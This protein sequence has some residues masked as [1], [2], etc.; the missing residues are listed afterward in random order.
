[1]E[2]L[3]QQI[4]EMNPDV[5]LDKDI[6][7][8]LVGYM[9]RASDDYLPVYNKDFLVNA[10]KMPEDSEFNSY[11]TLNISLSQ[12]SECEPGCL[13][14]DGFDDAII[15]LVELSDGEKVVLY[16]TYKCIDV[17]KVNGEMAEEDAWDYFYHKTVGTYM[18]EKTPAFMTSKESLISEDS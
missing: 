13:I 16:D 9:E 18:G 12:I 4:I 6:D 10:D 11:A 8:A 7:F 17:L 15:G 5:K 2:N 3:K 1:M 14:V